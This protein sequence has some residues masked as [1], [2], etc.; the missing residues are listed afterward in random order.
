MRGKAS[1]EEKKS[2]KA[3]VITEIPYML[4]KSDLI[5]QIAKLVQERKLQEI[6]NIRDESAKGKIRIVIELRRGTE[7]RFTLNKL[8]KYTRLQDR[9]DAQI[10]ALVK[11]KPMLLNLK[12]L[13]E[14]YVRHRKEVVKR[15]CKFELKQAKDRQEIVEGLLKALKNI[16]EIIE[17]IKKSKHASEASE[18]LVKK[19][20]FT[21]RQAKAILE[22]RLQQLTNLEHEKLKREAVELKKKIAELEKILASEKAILNVIKQELRELKRKYGDERKTVVLQR[23]RELS[24]KDLV[25][26][27]DVVIM[28]TDKG[29]VKRMDLRVYKEQRRGGKGVVG[30]DLATGDF[31]KEIITCSTHDYL[32]FFTE[33]GKVY[34]LKAYQVSETA[35]YGK[36]KAIVNLLNIRN[37]KIASVMAVSSFEDFLFMATKHGMVKKIELKLLEKTRASGVYVIRLPEQDSIIDVKR[38]KQGQE[39]M[40]VTA[41]GQA[42]RFNSD[43]V[44]VMTRASYGVTG[45]KLSQDDYV[46]SLVCAKP[47][48]YVLSITEHGFGKR[49]ALGEYRLTARAGKG[50]I[51][52]KVTERTGKVV[53]AIAVSDKDS[54]IVTT[55]KGMV[56]RTA[57]KD[58]RAMG[59]A[60]QGVR[61]V[62][63]QQDDK[64]TDMVKVPE[65]G[66]H[67][68][69][70]R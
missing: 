3:I 6:T 64:V 9:F 15:R 37:D 8:Y 51:N 16:D 65:A 47:D 19:Y 42:I 26:K 22:T 31:V 61:I 56:I 33:R 49:T 54:I 13:I 69:T 36:G 58:I 10:I 11:G 62:K 17:L 43:E 2:K 20:G 5:A 53:S 45:I 70:E 67:S 60:T 30:S 32:L 24:E 40:L 27:K 12:Q 7:P 38:V 68:D 18:K 39:V 25:Q 41:L 21:V 4:N 14:E 35:R 29:Y 59:R 34:W 63:L 1:I 46:V 57:V 55:A 44:R 23:V 28:I 50:V 66:N 48:A 52:M